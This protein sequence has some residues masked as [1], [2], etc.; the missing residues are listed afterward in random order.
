MYYMQMVQFLK[1]FPEREKYFVIDFDDLKADSGQVADEIFRWL[2]LET[3]EVGPTEP[4]NSIGYPYRLEANAKT[5]PV[6][7]KGVLP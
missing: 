5:I 3:F 7:W 1:Y 4:K 6:S 2:G